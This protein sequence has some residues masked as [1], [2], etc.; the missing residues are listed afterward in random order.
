MANK[1]SGANGLALDE[2][3][4]GVVLAA[5][6]AGV[7]LGWA[8]AVALGAAQPVL[9]FI[10]WIHFVEPAYRVAPFELGRA[11]ILVTVMAVL[12]LLLGAGLAAGWNAVCRLRR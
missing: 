7:H 3:S 8:V 9:D 5:M 4:A 12:G 10:F 2:L 1:A 6:L 11:T